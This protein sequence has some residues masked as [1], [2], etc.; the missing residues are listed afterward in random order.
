MRAYRPGALLLVFLYL[1]VPP[2][3]MLALRYRHVRLMAPLEIRE[4]PD[5]VRLSAFECAG[6]NK[7]ALA[8][9]LASASFAD[10][11][12]TVETLGF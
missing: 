2:L 7:E 9:K 6:L 12:A 11:V 3:A 5:E 8:R 4:L 1:E 10:L